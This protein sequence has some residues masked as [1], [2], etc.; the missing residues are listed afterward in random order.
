[1]YETQCKMCGKRMTVRTK[2]EIRSF[3]SKECYDAHMNQSNAKRGAK[4]EFEFETELKDM[5]DD[6]FITL[7]GAIVER[8]SH[9]V[10]L[11]PSGTE[12]RIT[13]EKFFL[14]DYFGE[15]TGL[16]GKPILDA[17]LAERR[18][19]MRKRKKEAKQNAAN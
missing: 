8:A 19:R 6:G 5:T 17:L 3:C 7:V 12:H 15:L 11:Y 16:E 1:M 10:L 13:A 2:L 9:D 18:E 4:W 14:S